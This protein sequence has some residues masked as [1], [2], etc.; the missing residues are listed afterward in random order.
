MLLGLVVYIYNMKK[1]YTVLRI[2]DG[3]PEPAFKT[4]LKVFMLR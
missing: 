1:V 2:Y 3:I 4:N